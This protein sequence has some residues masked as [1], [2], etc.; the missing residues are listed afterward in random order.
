MSYK[1]EEKLK[2]A[3]AALLHS[4]KMAAVGQLSA[5]IA[6]E[7]KNP[8][9]GILGYAQLSMRKLE[10]D[11]PIKNNL[12]VIEKETKRC[13]NIIGNLMKFSRKQENDKEFEALDI[14]T[15]VDEMIPTVMHQVRNHQIELH[16]ALEENIPQMLGDS[17]QLKQILLNFIINAQ[18]AM[19]EKR[20]KEKFT[21]LRRL[22]VTMKIS[23]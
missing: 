21:L 4:Q 8:L 19:E 6:H 22:Q 7:V 3:N 13:V 2:E 18:Q 16:T 9:A 15:V 23:L 5:G 10:S 12:E 1:R 17:D 20:S 11:S 14:N